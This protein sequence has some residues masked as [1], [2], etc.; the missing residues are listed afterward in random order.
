MWHV[1]VGLNFFQTIIVCPCHIFQIITFTHR[2]RRISRI[3]IF[4][5]GFTELFNVAMRLFFNGYSIAYR[6]RAFSRVIIRFPKKKSFFHT[7]KRKMKKPRLVCGVLRFIEMFFSQHSGY[8]R[9]LVQT[10]LWSSTVLDCTSR[11]PN[12]DESPGERTTGRE[13]E[14]RSGKKT[15]LFFGKWVWTAGGHATWNA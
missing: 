14:E 13:R 7:L 5:Y 6:P 4:K 1:S 11:R 3:R 9:V 12:R 8:T 15:G 10:R 2:A